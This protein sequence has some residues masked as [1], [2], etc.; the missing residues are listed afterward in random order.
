MPSLFDK[1]RAHLGEVARNFELGHDMLIVHVSPGAVLAS[2]IARAQRWGMRPDAP[3]D[4]TLVGQSE[5]IA[6]AG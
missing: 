6:A 1:V 3:S 4:R 2:T 5:P